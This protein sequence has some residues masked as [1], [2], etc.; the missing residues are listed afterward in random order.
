MKKYNIPNYIRYK[1]DLIVQLKKIED[2]P[3]QEL[4]EEQF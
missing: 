4:N 1:N 2:K 3:L